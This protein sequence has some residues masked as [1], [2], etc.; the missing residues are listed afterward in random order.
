[1]HQLVGD[2][3]LAKNLSWVAGIVVNGIDA[4]LPIKDFGLNFQDGMPSP[5]R[6]GPAPVYGGV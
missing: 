5:P 4:E 1:M 6:N 3:I 2:D